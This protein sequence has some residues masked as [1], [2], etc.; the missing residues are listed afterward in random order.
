M[1][2]PDLTIHPTADRTRQG[3][4]NVLGHGFAED[5]VALGGANVLDVFA[6]TGALGL[7]ALSRG[8]AHA[9]FIDN[10]R[11]AIELVRANSSALRESTRTTTLTRDAT[12]PGQPPRDKAPADIVFLDPPYSS[13][14]AGIAL[15]ALAALGWLRSGT[16]AA[17]EVGA[18]EPFDLPA[19]FE[20]IKDRRYGAARIEFLIW[21]G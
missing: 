15:S 8:A 6:G 2:G 20:R 3:L 11:A 21:R 16:A 18:R 10:N 1:A 19:G 9:I 13:G 4:F 14:F 5:G 17:I 7:E 12:A